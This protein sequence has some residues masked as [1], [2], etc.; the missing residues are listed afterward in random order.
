MP[1]SLDL[2]GHFSVYPSQLSTY[3][4]S[5]AWLLA[6][7]I[8]ISSSERISLMR[9]L[10]VLKLWVIS[11][12]V[13]CFAVNFCSAAENAALLEAINSIQADELSKHVEVLADDTFEGREAGSRGGRAAGGYLTKEM[14]KYGLQP[15]GIDGTWYQPYYGNQQN[16]LARIAGSDPKLKDQ[17]VLVSAHYDH[18]GYGSSTNSFGPIGFIHNGAD[19]NASGVSAVM[20]VAQAFHTLGVAPRRTVLFALWDGE[21]KGLLGSRHWLNQPTV[22]PKNVALSVNV[23]MV[24]RLR[25]K[26]VDVSGSRSSWGLRKMVS[27]QLGDENLVLDFNWE[28][29]SNSDHWPFFERGIPILMLHTGLHDDYHRPSDDPE[30]LNPEGM[31]Q[32]TRL[33]FRLTYGFADADEIGTF[34]AAARTETPEAGRRLE[35]ALPPEPPRLGVTWPENSEGPGLPISRVVS[36]SAAERAGLQ[37]GDTLLKLNGEELSSGAEL[38]QLLVRAE[39]PVQFE[40]LRRTKTEPESLQVALDGSPTRVGISWRLDE[41]EPDSVILVRVVPG[42]PAYE[43]GL[44]VG[45]RLYQVAGVNVKGSQALAEQLKELTGEIEIRAERTGRIQTVKLNILP[46]LPTAVAPTETPADAPAEVT[47]SEDAQATTVDPSPTE[48]P[49]E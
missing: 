17:V 42:S 4:L 7:D 20:E 39:S 9:Q 25:N 3:L 10:L 36:G 15:A 43:A 37:V 30:K 1:A 38:R 48:L 22:N 33:L 2:K 40:L 41:A 27:E 12:S 35:H 31:Q 16:I 21:E 23:D 11:L 45:D 28:L 34:R 49:A 13:V 8:K 14:A 18:V 6:L 24:G 19:D 29:K 47:E 44:K 26:R 5:V 46:I 32:V